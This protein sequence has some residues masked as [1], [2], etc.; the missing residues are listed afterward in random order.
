MQW[1][2]SLITSGNVTVAMQAAMLSGLS[3]LGTSYSDVS[4]SCSTGNCTF[5]DYSTL[6]ICASKANVTSFLTHSD[7]VWTLPN[8]HSLNYGASYWLNITTFIDNS[9]SLG[10]P[11][12]SN[13]LADIYLIYNPR[14]EILSNV[15]AFEIMLQICV[16]TLSTAVV[17]GKT[18]TN[19]TS[20]LNE[21]SYSGTM[22]NLSSPDSG[23]EFFIS[24]YARGPLQRALYSTFTGL[25]GYVDG[26]IIIT[27]DVMQAM[28]DTG[29]STDIQIS[30]FYPPIHNTIISMTNNMRLEPGGANDAMELGTAPEASGAAWSYDV[31]IE[32]SW[33]WLTLPFVLEVLALAFLLSVIQISSQKKIMAWKSSNL[34]VLRSLSAETSEALGG[35]RENSLMEREAETFEAALDLGRD[36]WKLKIK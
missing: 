29:N 31:F 30:G 8:G 10:Y 3:D 26:Q 21:S 20:T 14:K 2:L 13:P 32:V 35:M 27:S 24:D 36:G 6:G 7:G 9:T 23:Q 25:E 17:S 15:A 34:A 33:A 4:A 22:L 5:S 18:V 19:L 1:S 11:K 12:A 28:T 16:Q